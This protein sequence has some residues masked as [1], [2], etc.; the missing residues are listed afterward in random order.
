MQV[1]HVTAVADPQKLAD[2]LAKAAEDPSLTE[3]LGGSGSDL[4]QLGQG[5]TGDPAQAKE[6][7]K[8][9]KDASVDYWIGVEDSYM[10]KAQFAAAM[11]MT[12]QENMDGVTGITLK[13]SATMGD[14]DQPVEVTP[15]A[16][17]KSFDLFMNEL[18]GGMFGG[19]GGMML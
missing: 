18:F 19:S 4:G 9:L 8:T 10:Y 14:F 15:P 11:D 12:G 1:Y 2:S 16:D 5:L 13:G 17:A 3:K 6:L 7:A